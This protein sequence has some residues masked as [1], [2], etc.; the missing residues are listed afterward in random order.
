MT[1]RTAFSYV[2][3]VI[4]A[5]A[6]SLSVPSQAEASESRAS[7]GYGETASGFTGMSGSLAGS[8]VLTPRAGFGGRQGGSAT[9]Q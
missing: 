9:A 5:G 6:L 1:F 4:L 3:A 8:F 7:P 2:A